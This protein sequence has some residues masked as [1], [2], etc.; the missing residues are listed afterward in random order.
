MFNTFKNLSINKNTKIEN[1][2]ILKNN[3]KNQIVKIN[4]S[5]EHIA[6]FNNNNK[7]NFYFY[8]NMLYISIEENI[9]NISYEE[10]IENISNKVINL[11][12]TDKKNEKN[13]ILSLPISFFYNYNGYT[14]KNDVIIIP[15]NY[16]F[17]IEKIRF[18]KDY[19]LV[20]EIEKNLFDQQI[21]L[22]FSMDIEIINS[23]ENNEYT[24]LIQKIEYQKYSLNNQQQIFNLNFT[25]KAFHRTKGFFF[26][27][28][29]N[30]IDQLILKLNG[31]DRFIYDE[32]L[33]NLICK[34]INDNLFYLPFDI[35]INIEDCSFDAYNCSL[36]LG[37]FGTVV[38]NVKFKNVPNKIT[39]YALN[40]NIIKLFD[41][42][43]I[44]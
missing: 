8:P 14:I 3:E 18:S 9:K 10:I 21:N 43:N 7:S 35:N 34:K 6:I 41:N 39:I 30:S 28:N 27:G 1:N 40:S 36:N 2:E 16:K 4:F 38:F 25:D 5:K 19:F 22:L 29:I 37:E 12:I 23:K 31:L 24:T 33:L 26:E 13:I 15:L 17:F 44:L 11:S 42:K 32:I 20:I